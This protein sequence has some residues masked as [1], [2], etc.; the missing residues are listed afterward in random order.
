MS[1]GALG[2]P[3]SRVA[4]PLRGLGWRHFLLSLPGVVV[5]LVPVAALPAAAA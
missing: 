5:S 3:M 2:Q 4:P 1:R